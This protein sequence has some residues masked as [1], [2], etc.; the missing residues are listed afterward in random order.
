MVIPVGYFHIKKSGGR[1]AWTLPQ[2]WRQN[3]G[4]CNEIRGKVWGGVGLQLAQEAET[5]AES[6]KTIKNIS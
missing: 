1:G 3:L 4:H 6:Q 5:G 2:V